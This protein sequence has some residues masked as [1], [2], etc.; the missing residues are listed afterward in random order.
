MLIQ[1]KENDC[2]DF[3]HKLR[4]DENNKPLATQNGIPNGILD[5]VQH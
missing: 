5:S 4:I 2:Q 1:T 3:I